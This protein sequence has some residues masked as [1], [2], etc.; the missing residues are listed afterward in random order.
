MAKLE[1]T[2]KAFY[3]LIKVEAAAPPY[4]LIY[5]TDIK[6]GNVNYQTETVDLSINTILE[7]NNAWFNATRK[8]FGAA[9][10]V[11]DG[12]NSTKRKDEWG[13]GGWPRNGVTNTNPF[14]RSRDYEIKVVFEL[15]NQQG[16]VIGSQTLGLNPRF[17]IDGTTVNFTRTDVNTVTFKGVKA[18]DISDNLTIRIASV[19]DTPPQQVRFAII[20]ESTFEPS[21]PLI[22]TR[23]GKRY[24]TVRI[25]GKTWMGENLNYQPSTGNSWCYD[26]NNANCAKYGRLYDWNTAMNACPAGWHLPTKEEW[27]YLESWTGGGEAGKRQK[28]KSGWDG[29]GNGTDEY[30]VSASPGGYRR[31]VGSFN[32]AGKYGYWWTATEGGSGRAYYRD[33]GY[34]TNYVGEYSYGKGGG[35]SVRCVAD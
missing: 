10:A 29:N 16:R 6:Q 4:S 17:S 32:Y 2:E 9:Q 35:F 28:A 23:N 19:N 25:G 20:A 1:E 18:N 30:G 5:F 3:E 27:K 34:S 15:V 11:M 33:M 21:P 7:A 13:L 22:D 14:N 31:T 8:A 24:K 26:N 12:L